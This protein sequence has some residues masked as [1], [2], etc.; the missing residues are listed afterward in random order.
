VETISAG[1]SSPETAVASAKKEARARFVPDR[2]KDIESPPR[3][4][5]MLKK[6]FQKPTLTSL[7]KT[8]G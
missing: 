7:T 8:C 4:A 3:S 5:Y 6:L 2:R 1:D